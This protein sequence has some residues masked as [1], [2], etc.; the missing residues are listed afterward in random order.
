MSN[1]KI[2]DKVICI[3]DSGWTNEKGTALLYKKEYTILDIT[4]CKDCGKKYYDV[5]CKRY[6]TT[7]HNM[8]CNKQMIGEGID[9]VC[10]HRLKPYFTNF[11]DFTRIEIIET[12]HE[13]IRILVKKKQYEK[14]IELIKRLEKI[15]NEL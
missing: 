11:K 15:N 9:W 1:I 2:G 7:T 3:D 5:G 10:G 12:I 8:C 4:I 13:D 14:A 6:D